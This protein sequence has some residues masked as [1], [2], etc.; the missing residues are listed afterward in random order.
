MSCNLDLITGG[1]QLPHVYCKKITL[2]NNAADSTKT[3][4]TVLLELYQE[5]NNLSKSSWLQ[6]SSTSLAGLP[7][8]LDALYIQPLVFTKHNNVV[9][10]APSYADSALSDATPAGAINS[11]DPG[12]QDQ[13]PGSA[14]AAIQVL[15]SGALP[16]SIFYAGFE[17]EGLSEQ[18]KIFEV[19][20][21]PGTSLGADRPPIHVRSSSMINQNLNSENVIDGFGVGSTKEVILNGKPYYVIPF[22]YKIE[23]FDPK[24]M[25]GQDNLGFGF[26]TFLHI[27]DWMTSAMPD[28]FDNAFFQ[29]FLEQLVIEGPLNTEIVFLNGKVHQTREAFF[30]PSG[31][32]WEGSVHLHASGYNPA[33]DGYAGDGA[34]SSID[35]GAPYRGW[36]AGANHSAQDLPKLRLARVPNNKVSDFRHGIFDTSDFDTVLGSDLPI[37]NEEYSKIESFLSP[38][39]KV[40]RKYFIKDN[41]SEFS[42]FY[43]SRDIDN[44]ARGLFFIDMH[45]LLKNNSQIFPLL[46]GGYDPLLS[47]PPG[48]PSSFQKYV[49]DKILNRS[50]ILE[51]KVYRDRVK[52]H[53]IGSRRENYF[54]DKDYE[55]PS[56]LVGTL[57]DVQGYQSPNQNVFLA[58]V[59]GLPDP[60]YKRYFMLSDIE[61]GHM[62]AGLYQ[63][64]VELSFKDGTHE[65][66]YDIYKELANQK[67]LLDEYYDAA[68]SAYTDSNTDIKWNRGLIAQ[69]DSKRIFKTYW[70]SESFADPEFYEAVND[71]SKF[72]NLAEN[73]PWLTAPDLLHNIQRL[74][75]IYPEM[76]DGSDFLFE[77]PSTTNLLSPVDGSPKGIEFFSKLTSTAMTKV[78]SLIGASKNKKSG[79]EL[80]SQE[81]PD[82][83]TFDNILNIVISRGDYTIEEQ[84]SYENPV[85]M[86][87]GISNDNIYVDYLST[88]SPLLSSFNG[89]R[90]LSTEYFDTR[91]RLEA[92]KFTT[93]GRTLASFKGQAPGS[94]IGLYEG[95]AQIQNSD[96]LEAQGYSYITPSIVQLSDPIPGKSSE[97]YNYYYTAFKQ[98]AP[99]YLESTAGDNIFAGE[100]LLYAS[101]FNNI[102][103]YDRLFVALMNY[104]LGKTSQHPDADLT[105]LFLTY[106]DNPIGGPIYG[107]KAVK[108]LL[109]RREPLKR[110][111]EELGITIHDA[112]RHNSFFDKPS[113]ALKPGIN[114][115]FPLTPEDYSDTVVDHV[116]FSKNFL[117]NTK[118]N[119]VPFENHGNEPYT[120]NPL[121]PNS[122]KIKKIH[123]DH[124]AAG[125]QFILQPTMRAALENDQTYSSFFFFNLN[126]T[127]KIEV[128]RGTSGNAKNDEKSWSLLTVQDL[129]LDVKTNQKLF[130]RLSVYDQSLN[131]FINLPIID[132]YFLIYPFATDQLPPIQAEATVE[133]EFNDGGPR[134]WESQNQKKLEEMR[135]TTEKGIMDQGR[136][137]PMPPYQEIYGPDTGDRGQGGE[138]PLPGDGASPIPDIPGLGGDPV[139][140]GLGGQTGPGFAG[141]TPGGTGPDILPGGDG[142]GYN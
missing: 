72:K 59:T 68:V 53:V 108:N 82:G 112:D 45:E 37:L 57:S 24:N 116:Q 89:L 34:L 17:L 23:N 33:P 134:F 98:N 88:G 54:N 78:Q 118:Q 20:T 75:E 47:G 1:A 119:I 132:K 80:G 5:K 63:Y 64:R 11:F 18:N 4:V 104:S 107:G 60:L 94:N 93:L 141:Q 27:P 96:T 127:T 92:S 32:S 10:L 135:N 39:Q 41:D 51:L 81:T 28:E 136:M 13:F 117:L 9:K 55:E 114:K 79:S 26:Y 22:E 103:N 65:Y 29:E 69:E 3:D 73:T 102:A 106:Y 76:F 58:E 140:P 122:F 110:T 113:G 105:D 14:H 123:D 131:K 70:N 38:F 111:M 49:I 43:L 62:S 52:K 35:D 84:H 86:F 19:E 6:E 48:P 101:N 91:M 77:N 2:E 50:K 109:G 99:D 133:K 44:N 115:I 100:D 8:I 90:S 121:L 124:V 42:K 67:I 83:Y 15:S 46:F 87:Q 40:K 95:T 142:P 66:M 138:G 139:G 97:E 126:L 21:F 120:Y 25:D 125:K 61:V 130:C 36:M 85:E 7:S 129:S 30:L 31:L 137:D 128:F 74:L 12:T 16:R 56:T 71:P